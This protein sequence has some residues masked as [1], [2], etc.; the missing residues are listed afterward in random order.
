M[1]TAQRRDVRRRHTEVPLLAIISPRMSVFLFVFLAM[2]GRVKES[3]VHTR[4]KVD[5]F[6]PE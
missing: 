1:V 6:H 3:V 4:K 2:T 5:I